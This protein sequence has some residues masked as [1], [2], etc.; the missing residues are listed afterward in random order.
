MD[1]E[2]R[3][4]PASANF[5]KLREP[6]L[7]LTAMWRAWNAVPQAPTA[8]GEVKMVGTLNFVTAFGQR[9]MSS[10]TVFNFYEPDYQQPGAIADAGLFAPEFQIT[11]ESTVYT[12]SNGLY[13]FSAGAYVGM[14]GTVP[15]DRPLLD[16]SGLAAKAHSG[17][18]AGMV[19]D[20]N[21]LMLYGSMPAAM[22]TTLQ[23][24]LAFMSG[25]TDLEK[26]WSLVYLVAISPNYA[27][28]R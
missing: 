25:A 18:Y 11:N 4:A 7:R 3:Q 12:L 28:Q 2:A 22:Q 23:N 21:R 8:Y 26:S 17:D 9:P 14:S 13:A 27:A 10:P 24:M 20:A 16:L 5:G 6:V 19:A 15:T 1:D